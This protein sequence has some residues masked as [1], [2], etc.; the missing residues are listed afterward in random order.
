MFRGGKHDFSGHWSG[1]LSNK[2]L[3]GVKTWMRMYITTNREKIT[4]IGTAKHGFGYINLLQWRYNECNGISNHLHLDCL[5]NRLFRRRSKETS[6][7]HATGF[8]EENSPVTGKFL[9]QKASNTENV[10]IWWCLIAGSLIFLFVTV[11][12]LQHY[13]MVQSFEQCW[14]LTGP[15]K[16]V[17]APVQY[18]CEEPCF[19]RK[20]K[21]GKLWM[22]KI[23][24]VT[25]SQV[26]NSNCL[27]Y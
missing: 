11:L 3:K 8:C 16:A 7:L 18:E 20:I 2:N 17:L 5:L 9:A 24:V 23:G 19:D 14:Y 13:H 4:W 21:I 12:I 6:K 25:Y 26:C 1:W 22:A 10:S 15:T 27:F